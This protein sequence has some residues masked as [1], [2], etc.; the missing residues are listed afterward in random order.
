MSNKKK[1]IFK[2]LLTAVLAII[3]FASSVIISVAVWYNA[4]FDITFNDLLYT[5]LSP[6]G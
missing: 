6:I 3:F 1:L 5:M 2:I 4:T